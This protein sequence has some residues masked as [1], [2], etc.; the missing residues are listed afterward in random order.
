MCGIAGIVDFGGITPRDTAL[1]DKMLLS[2]A[3]RGPDDQFCRSDATA[4][5]GARRLSIIDLDTGRQ[6]LTNEDGTIWATQ[7]GEIYNY[8]ELRDL[9][10][11]RG[12]HM[13][14][15]GDTEAIV[16]LY[17]DEGAAVPEQLRG[18]FAIAIWD[19]TQR[20]LIL[21]RDRLGK[22]PLYWRISNGRCIYASEM[23]ALLVD[24]ARCRA[25]STTTPWPYTCNTNTCRRH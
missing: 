2:L 13:T 20:K 17:E 3:H 24:G 21:A 25:R 15:K 10:L 19:S 16:H 14:T 8:V 12:H 5:I 9:L 11:E 6:P 1:T 7:N 22:K 4:A 18:M 23:K